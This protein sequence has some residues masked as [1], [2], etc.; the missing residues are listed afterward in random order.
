MSSGERLADQY[1][2]DAILANCGVRPTVDV[3]FQ[4]FVNQCFLGGDC[5]GNTVNPPPAQRASDPNV[6]YVSSNA[7]GSISIGLAGDLDSSDLLPPAFNCSL[8]GGVQQGPLQASEVVKFEVLGAPPAQYLYSF[9]A[10]PSG[11]TADD[12]TASYD[13]TYPIRVK[14]PRPPPT[15]IPAVPTAGLFI[16]LLGLAFAG[17]GSLRRRSDGR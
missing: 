9:S 11:I 10:A 2:A 7:D 15:P 4:A 16:T 14:C 17:I 6:A 3:L 8:V 1:L 12:P 13:G 5:L